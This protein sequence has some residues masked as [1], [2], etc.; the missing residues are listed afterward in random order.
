M[1][2][3]LMGIVV[4]NLS[5]KTAKAN[6]NKVAS[7]HHLVDGDLLL[8]MNQ[9]LTNARVVEGGREKNVKLLPFATTQFFVRRLVRHFAENGIDRLGRKERNLLKKLANR[10]APEYITQF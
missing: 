7:A 4:G 8:V 6:I 9:K 10:Y 3:K 1:Q 2:G 5:T